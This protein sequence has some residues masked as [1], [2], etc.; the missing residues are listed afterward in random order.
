MATPTS[1]PATF[2]SNVLT[3]T[4]MNNLRGAFRVLQVK[5][6]SYSTQTGSTSTTYVT[7][8]LTQSIT[9]QATTNSILITGTLSGSIAGAND[10]LGFRLVRTIGG[11]DTVIQT[12][13]YALQ[14]N[15]GNLYSILPFTILETPNTTSAC[16][17]TIQFARTNGGGAVYTQVASQTPSNIILQEISG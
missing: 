2:G 8:G 1:L 7:S 9:P 16:T 15:S 14:S 4:E 17:Y 12:F 13:V 10:Q 5:S 11:S 3:S 6:A